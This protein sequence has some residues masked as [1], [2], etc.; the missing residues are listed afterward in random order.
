[1]GSQLVSFEKNS[2]SKPQGNDEVTE[3][4]DLES[5]SLQTG[6]QAILFAYHKNKDNLDLSLT[7]SQLLSF[8]KID[9]ITFFT[10]TLRTQMQQWYLYAQL[11]TDIFVST[12]GQQLSMEVL[13]QGGVL[14]FWVS[15][16]F[17]VA[18]V[19]NQVSLN[20]RITSMVLLT[21]VWLVRPNYFD[22]LSK[23]SPENMI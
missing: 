4:K 9:P 3:G 20:D 1:M 12:V 11:C 5:Y 22:P 13:E 8:A 15:E 19:N 17:R 7:S 14:K 21:E 6:L 2:S 18:D 23:G 16:C 10:Q